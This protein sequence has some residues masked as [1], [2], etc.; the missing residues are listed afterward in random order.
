M[1]AS[2]LRLRIFD[3]PLTFH[4]DWSGWKPATSSQKATDEPGE[5]QQDSFPKGFG[6]S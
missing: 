6:L 1:A 2:T 4:P 5:G 3:G